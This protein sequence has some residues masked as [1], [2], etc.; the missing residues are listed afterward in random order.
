MSVYYSPRH[1]ALSA[2][3]PCG[4]WEDL[5]GYTGLLLEGSPS[6]L[7]VFA[8]FPSR[9]TEKYG[10]RGGRFVMIEAGHYLQQLGLRVAVE[11]LRGVEAGGM[12]DDFFRQALGLEDTDAMIT[13]GMAVG[14]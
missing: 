14:N 10:E 13:L 3:G 4:C 2:V 8:A 6:A 5:S 7:F 11:R 9:T 12:Y 1:H